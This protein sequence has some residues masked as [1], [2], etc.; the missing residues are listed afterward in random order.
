[1]HCSSHS[2]V[3]ITCYNAWKVCVCVI[4]MESCTTFKL[5]VVE[6]TL[7]MEWNSTEKVHH[8]WNIYAKLNNQ[9]M[10][11]SCKHTCLDDH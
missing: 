10:L 3:I 11:P 5:R 4:G 9:K 8:W 6:C 1:M 7:K 2:H